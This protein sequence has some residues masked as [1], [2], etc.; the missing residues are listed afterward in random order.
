MSNDLEGES[1]R[2]KRGSGHNTNPRYKRFNQI[3]FTAGDFEQFVTHR[4]RDASPTGVSRRSTVSRLELSADETLSDLSP[5]YQEHESS[6]V[7]DTFAYIFHKFKKG[8]YVKIRNNQL[9]TFLPFS[10]AAFENEWADL[11]RVGPEYDGSIKKFFDAHYAMCS[12]LRK[13]PTRREQVHFNPSKWYANNCLLRYEYP[14]NEEGNN[15]PQLK[16]MFLELCESRVVPDVEF[17]LN[18]RD[19]PLLARDGTEAYFHIFGRNVP[20]RSLRFPKHTP[21][22][23]M[24]TSDKYADIAC[25]THEDWARVKSQEGVLYPYKYA[26][27]SA[28]LNTTWANKHAR[29]V[30]RGSNTGCGYDASTNGRL[31]L[32][33]M[34]SDVLDV[35][36]TNFNMRVR[37]H[38][39]SPF[40]QIPNPTGVALVDRLTPVEQSNFKFIINIDGH[41]SAFRLSLELGMGSCILLVDSDW[42]MWFSDK[43]KRGVHYVPVKRDLSNLQQQVD[44]CLA[45]DSECE[46]I[47]QNALRFYQTHLSKHAILNHLQSRMY[48]LRAYCAPSNAPSPDPVITLSEQQRSSLVEEQPTD[49]RLT[50]LFPPSPRRYG[51]LRGLQSFI[52]RGIRPTDAITLAGVEVRQLFKSKTTTVT[53]HQL[54]AAYFV[55]KT[56]TDFSKRIEFIHEAFIGKAVINELSM[57]CPHFAFTF[58]YREEPHYPHETTVLQEYVNGPTLQTFIRKGF[59]SFKIYLEILLQVLCALRIG[60]DACVFQHLDLKPWNVM[61]RVLPEPVVTLYRLR[62]WRGAASTLYKIKTRFIPVLIDFGKSSVMAENRLVQHFLQNTSPGD[63]RTFISSCLAE[64]VAARQ[65]DPGL[66][67]VTILSNDNIHD[68]LFDTLHFFKQISPLLRDYDVGFGK[69]P[70]SDNVHTEIVNARQIVDVAFGIEIE[71]KVNA[72]LDVCSRIYRRPLPQATNKLTTIYIARTLLQTLSSSKKAFALFAQDVK[73]PS[74][75]VNRVSTTYEKTHTFLTT[76]YQKSIDKK[77][78]TPLHIPYFPSVKAAQSLSAEI[79]RELLLDQSKLNRIAIDFLH[80]PID[81]PDY[82]KLG[83]TIQ[84]ILESTDPLFPLTTEDKIFYRQTCE[85]LFD[86]DYIQKISFLCTVRQYSK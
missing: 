8:I 1:A 61:V 21:I 4:L 42:K 31:K 77:T 26:D 24:C 86:P 37:K 6:T 45:H 32:A 12:S 82:I 25:P 27:Y 69:A 41:V 15:L 18:K 48:Q 72:F 83:T 5:Q 85:Q 34:R 62:P 11:I 19:F 35:G 81:L 74:H 30:F 84:T 47:A 23:G 66:A 38:C 51:A 79:T 10:K 54:G 28:E 67:R 46:Q 44:W 53:L 16:A 22:L 59:A 68:D 78:N 33:S 40:L 65:E 71:D 43:L 7:E 60:Q 63:E 3:Y 17:F 75:V 39:D 2:A 36:I 49:Y 80:V 9:H 56:T 50:G 20:L 13:A 29:A 55:A 70:E 64:F 14:I 52:E 76:F 57:L 73:L 58:N